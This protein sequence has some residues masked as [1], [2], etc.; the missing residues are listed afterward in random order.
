MLEFYAKDKCTVCRNCV[1]CDLYYDPIFVLLSALLG[2]ILFAGF[3]WG[4]V[5]YIIFLFIWEI[6]YWIYTG[7]DDSTIWSPKLRLGV[8]LVALF[9]FII[10]RTIHGCDDFGK[11]CENFKNYMWDCLE[12]S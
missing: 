11:D 6:G 2:G 8:V 7:Y 9:G 10:G 12:E 3:S 1:K 4:F 5:Y